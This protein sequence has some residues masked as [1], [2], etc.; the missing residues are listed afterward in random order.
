MNNNDDNLWTYYQIDNAQN[1]IQGHPRQEMLFRKISKLIKDGKVL[2]IGF[3]DGYLLNKL[4]KKY[5]SY[6]VD[7]SEE[8]IKKNAKINPGVNFK[9]IDVD[10]KLPFED[11]FFDVFV[12]SEVLEHMDDKELEV[13]I[14]EIKRILKKGGFGILTFPAE[15]NL[16]KNECFCPNCKTEFHKWGHKQYF[17]R[18]IIRMKFSE[19]QIINI[20]E[21]FGRH[22]GKTLFDS[23]FGLFAWSIQTFINY[24]I[25]FPNKFVTNRSYVVILK[26]R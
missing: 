22:I 4:S 7:I 2:E 13:C 5:D 17:N 21:Y 1:L 20:S 26:K 25:E 6:G 8:N 12:A 9:L 18:K 10:G 3:G 23:L 19:F 24:F 14:K 11:N 16:K 15:E